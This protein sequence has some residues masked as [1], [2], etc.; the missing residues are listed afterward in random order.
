MRVRLSLWDAAGSAVISPSVMQQ[1]SSNIP[2]GADLQDIIANFIQ[3]TSL[4]V[5]GFYIL[6]M[7]SDYLVVFIT[8]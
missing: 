5:F 1:N 8:L 2:K 4:L 3:S 7:T 6:S